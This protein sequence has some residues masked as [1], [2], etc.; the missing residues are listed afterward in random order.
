MNKKGADMKL[1][2]SLTINEAIE[3]LE[4]LSKAINYTYSDKD[5]NE[6]VVAISMGIRAL[7]KVTM[8]EL[9]DLSDNN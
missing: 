9:C 8:E 1:K 2:P 4:D 3:R 5:M 7:R 6:L